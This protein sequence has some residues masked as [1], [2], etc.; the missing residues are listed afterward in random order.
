MEILLWIGFSQSLFSA[1][2]F[3]LVKKDKSLANQILSAWLFILAIEFLTIAIDL[4]RGGNHLTNP[5][6]IFNPLLYFYA[7][8][9][10]KPVVKLKWVQLWHILPYLFIKIGALI[11]GFELEFS[12]FY[13]ISGETWFNLVYSIVSIISFFGYSGF[14]LMTVHRYRINLKNELSTISSK[15]TL[16]WLLTV[17]VFYMTFMIIAYTLGL[18][19]FITD[20]ETFPVVVTYSFLL[21]LVY[22]FSFYGL[23][24]QQLYSQL[25]SNQNE[26]Y[27]NPRLT[28]E[29]TAGELSKMQAYFLEEKPYLDSEFTIY[30]LSEQMNMSRHIITEVLNTGAGKNF[31][32]FVNE[33]RVEEVKQ[34]LKDP[35]Y[36]KYS[37]DAIGFECGFK[38]KSSFYAVFKKSTG[39]TPT[40]YRSG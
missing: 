39:L 6:L 33:Y 19:K 4:S 29:Q 28:P 15:V 9:L 5:F 20:A 16:G 11:G 7:R 35:R 21:G 18:I 24:Q 25:S 36:R 3:L 31:Y 26:K 38:S 8:S 40:Q 2:L 12:D 10:I 23:L 13:I 17:I 14:S 30:M 22:I 32:Q 27:K 34:L 37:I 1:T